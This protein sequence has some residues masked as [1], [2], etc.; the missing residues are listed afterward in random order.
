[1][2]KI[3]LKPNEFKV[4]E[5]TNMLEYVF[6]SA[7]SE[8]VIRNKIWLIYSVKNMQYKN[9]WAEV[10]IRSYIKIQLRDTLYYHY[11]LDHSHLHWIPTQ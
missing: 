5:A 1:M 2:A 10:R 11:Y 8:S 9:V 7:E 3:G 4:D 6:D